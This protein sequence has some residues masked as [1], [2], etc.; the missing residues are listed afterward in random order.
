MQPEIQPTMQSEEAVRPVMACCQQVDFRVGCQDPEPVMLP[1]ECL[2][3]CALGQIP[4]PDA[5][6]LRVGHNHVL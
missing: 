4:H 2:H 1:P 5:L 3:S 6:V